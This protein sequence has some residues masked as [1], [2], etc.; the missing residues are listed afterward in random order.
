MPDPND[1]KSPE[2][3]TI[4]I[5]RDVLPKLRAYAKSQD[6]TVMGQ[7][8]WW[9]R[10]AGALEPPP[11]GLSRWYGRPRRRPHRVDDGVTL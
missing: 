11:V 5:H 1:N 2:W 6:R 3:T 4:E 7:L 10:M 9:L 8:R